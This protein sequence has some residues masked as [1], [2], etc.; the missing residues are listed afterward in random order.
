MPNI[1]QIIEKWQG[2]GRTSHSAINLG[3]SVLRSSKFLV[4]REKQNGGLS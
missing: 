4:L 3:E 1:L 2:N